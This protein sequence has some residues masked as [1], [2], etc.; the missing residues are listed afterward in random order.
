M[1]AGHQLRHITLATDL[2]ARSDRATERAIQLAAQFQARLL[3]VHAVEAAAS[4]VWDGGPSWRRALDL[5]E[6]ARHR[7]FGDLP[8]SQG[9]DI[10]LVVER[11]DPFELV[12]RA[13]TDA[14]SD[15][16]VTGVAREE[17]YGSS[18]AGRMVE[19]LASRAPAPLLV[20]K[21]KPARPYRNLLIAIDLSPTS[22]AALH[23]ARQWW[24]GAEQTLFH[25]VDL[26]YASLIGDL[27]NTRRSVEDGAARTCREW[28]SAE[29]GEAEAKAVAVI[30]AYGE[31][32]ALIGQFVWEKPVDLVVTGTERKGILSR[33]IL[34]SV[35]AAVVE[36]APADVLIVP[37]GSG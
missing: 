20:V 25:A 33:A 19:Q 10:D 3:V 14:G 24:P 6:I 26:S 16:L 36:K 17:V 13:C 12:L 27:E 37:T 23:R 5:A 4:A 8:L 31:P 21:R 9:V 7:L 18:R 2:T 29:L 22:A 35:A 32:S 34:G 15:L 1:T 30:A 11:G 28:A